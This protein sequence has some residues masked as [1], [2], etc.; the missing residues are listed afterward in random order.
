MKYLIKL[1][2][3]LSC[4]ISAC[5]GGPIADSSGKDNQ[6]ALQKRIDSLEKKIADTYKPGFGEFMSSVQIHHAKLWFAG[7]NK[8]WKLAEFE[9]KEIMEALANI[10]KYE[11]ERKES[12]LINTLDP[13]LDSINNAIRK[14]NPVL[15]KNNFTLFTNACNNCHKESDFEFNIVKIPD[16]APFSNQDF[17]TE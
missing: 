3:L 14:Q 9:V 2:F 5:C 17:K 10:K 6:Q 4:L 11:T 15:F 1:I 13:S 12:Q 7:Q 16:T 8:N